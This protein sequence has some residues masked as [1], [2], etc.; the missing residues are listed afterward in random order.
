M[1][2]SKA[3]FGIVLVGIFMATTTRLKGTPL[4]MTSPEKVGM[5]SERLAKVDTV[6]NENIANK[7]TPGAVLLVARK[8]KVVYKKAYGNRMVEPR[9]EKM[10]LDTIFDMASLTKPTAT[11]SGIMKLVE[12]GK[13][14]LIDK[15][16]YYIPEFKENGKKDVTLVNLL[17]HTSGLPAWDKYFE[18]KLNPEEIILDIASKATTYEPGTKFVY[19]DLGYITLGEIIKRVS[20]KPENEFVAEQIYKPLGMKDTGFLPPKDKWSRCAPTEM[21]D[22]KMLQGEVHDGN[23]WMLGGVAGHAGL[24]S[25]ADDMAIF[26]Q[27][28]LNGGEYNGVRIFSP[29]TVRAMTTNQSPLKDE[30][31]GFGWDIGT[32]YAGQR[33]DIFPALQGFGHTG[34]TGTSVWVDPGSQT[35]VILLCNRVHP[36]GK[37]EILRMRSLVS[38]VVASSIIK[39]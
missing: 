32:A 37:G 6:I 15:V 4:P 28:I 18:K 9:I 2:R 5:S 25:T 13:I 22:G 23:A 19:S 10:T 12:D 17:T 20:G 38:N 33:G 27:M 30:Q 29:L 39:E 35:F 24:F 1:K 36:D 26:C 8:G 16:S 14:R 31:R 3:L 34:F 21:R 11:A 7:E